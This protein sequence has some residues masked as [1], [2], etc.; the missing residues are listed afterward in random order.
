MSIVRERNAPEIDENNQLNNQRSY[1]AI[2]PASVRYCK[3]LDFGARLLFAEISCLTNYLGY[4]WASNDHFV[5]CFDVD[6][7]TIRRW[8]DS[9]KEEGF[10]FVDLEK[11]GFITKRRIWLSEEIKKSFTTGRQCPPRPDINA[12]TRPDTDVRLEGTPMSGIIEERFNKKNDDGPLKVPNQQ[13]LKDPESK[14]PVAGFFSALKELQL[15]DTDKQS[16]MKFSEDDVNHAVA[17]SK[18]VPFTT[19][20]I[21]QLMWAAQKRPPI[22][23]AVDPEDN[24][25]HAQ[26]AESALES[27]FWKIEALNASVEIVSKVPTQSSASTIVF[28]Y[29][30]P[31]FKEKFE[32]HLRKLGFRKRV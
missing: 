31:Q 29:E 32:G 19:T 20:L 13:I 5:D 1:F 8:L 21:Q 27:E 12:K 24:R 2:I 9:L 3:K 26:K 11:S 25:K 23:K 6:E 18:A 30:E 14:A 15:S 17:Y 28:S 10:I 16:L 22:P 4:C 7:R